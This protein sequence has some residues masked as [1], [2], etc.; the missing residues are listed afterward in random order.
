MAV[1]IFKQFQTAY[2]DLARFFKCKQS[3]SSSLGD[4][5]VAVIQVPRKSFVK[6]VYLEVLTAYTAASTGSVT[7][8]YEAPDK[9]ANATFFMDNTAAAPLT[10][11]MKTAAKGVYFEKGGVISVTFAKGDSAANVVV[12]AFADISTIY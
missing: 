12:R 9:A 10:V 5:G 2:S 8:G 11:G 7:V 1:S 6:A 4:V 3:V